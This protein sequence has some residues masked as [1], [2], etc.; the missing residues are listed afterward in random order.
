MSVR[1]YRDI[2]LDMMHLLMTDTKRIP[3]LVRELVARCR[4][5][6][7]TIKKA[8]ISSHATD[9]MAV[10]KQILEVLGLCVVK[11]N[12]LL[13]TIEQLKLSAAAMTLKERQTLLDAILAPISEDEEDEI[14]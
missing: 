2:P 1:E 12:E 8:E 6:D 7:A 13:P 14:L 9:A 10:K 3:R 4:L 5:E 11:Y